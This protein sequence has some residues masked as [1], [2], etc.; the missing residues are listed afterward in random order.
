MCLC[1]LS[2]RVKHLKQRGHMLAVS[3]F[4]S[5]F[6]LVTKSMYRKSETKQILTVSFKLEIKLCNQELSF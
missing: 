6:D 3:S 1:K 2:F 4:M 5:T